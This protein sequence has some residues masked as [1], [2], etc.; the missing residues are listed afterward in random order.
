MPV[1]PL[2]LKYLMLKNKLLMNGY[3]STMLTVL[4]NKKIRSIFT[5]PELNKD[6]PNS[7]L[8]PNTL[9]LILDS[10][11]NLEEDKEVCSLS[12]DSSLELNLK[13]MTI[14]T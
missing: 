1:L 12:M 5:S 7:K 14:F 3:S 4:K 8:H 2:I 10:N 6:L 13:L 11:S 9:L